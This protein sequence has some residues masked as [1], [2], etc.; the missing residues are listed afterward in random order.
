MLLVIASS[1]ALFVAASV[2]LTRWVT[3]SS[4]S[5]Y[6][7]L[8]WSVSSCSEDG[9]IR[10]VLL[11][12][13]VAFLLILGVISRRLGLRAG[14]VAVAVTALSYGL[15]VWV[16]GLVFRDAGCHVVMFGTLTGYTAREPVVAAVVIVLSAAFAFA[17]ATIGSLGYGLW[18]RLHVSR[19]F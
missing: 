11:A 14:L 6:K 15:A 4:D 16:Q 18:R 5:T 7:G 12:G 10:N 2:P 3:V 8:E 17:I 13:S 19:A 9:A 1:T